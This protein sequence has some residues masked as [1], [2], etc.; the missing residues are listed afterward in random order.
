MKPGTVEGLNF[1]IAAAE[2]PPSRAELWFRR[3][4]LAL[5]VVVCVEVGMV[6][7]VLPW[8]H[9]WTDNS[10]LISNLTLRSLALQ[11]FVRGLVSGLGLINVWMGIWEA[12]HYR[13]P[14]GSN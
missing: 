10:L 8:T 13:E 5:F 3:L 7:V 6:L 14:K 9:A 11:N 4:T 1:G 12:V 2:V